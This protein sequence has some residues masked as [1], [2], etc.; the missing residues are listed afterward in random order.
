MSIAST[1]ASLT[2]AESTF[3]FSADEKAGLLCSSFS[4]TGITVS[5]CAFFKSSKFNLL[6]I[7][8]L[9]NSGAEPSRDLCEFEFS[10]K[11]L[12]ICY[13]TLKI[14]KSLRFL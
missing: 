11:S 8:E 5:V 13:K 4:V 3:R 7:S 12:I 9:Y 14:V 10:L 1:E 6:N 2:T